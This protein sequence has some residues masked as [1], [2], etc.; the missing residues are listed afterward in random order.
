MR[1]CSFVGAM[2]WVCPLGW[3]G[4]LHGERGFLPV[5]LATKSVMQAFIRTTCCCCFLQVTPEQC[6]DDLGGATDAQLQ[7]LADWEAKFLQK[8]GVAGLVV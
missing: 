8:Y 7:T 6:T 1:I 5:L 2:I 4:G 3:E